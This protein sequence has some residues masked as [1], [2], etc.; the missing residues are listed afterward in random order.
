MKRMKH[1]DPLFLVVRTSKSYDR[2]DYYDRS[3]WRV[4]AFLYNTG[5]LCVVIVLS[6]YVAA[7]HWASLPFIARGCLALVLWGLIIFWRVTVGDHRRIRELRQQLPSDKLGNEVCL[8]ASG[9]SNYAS[10]TLVLIVFFALVCF[11]STLNKL[12]K[13]TRDRNSTPGRTVAVG[14]VSAQGQH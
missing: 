5:A 13:A 12:D 1:F 8:I 2:T 6:V 14:H 9:M 10:W 11:G 3:I 7:V 4:P